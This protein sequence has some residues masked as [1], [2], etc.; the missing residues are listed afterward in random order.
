M[1]QNRAIHT[2]Y[3]LFLIL[4]AL[5]LLASCSKGNTGIVDALN[6]KAYLF[7]YRNL[8]STRIYAQRAI[9]Y[10]SGYNDGYA[11]AL[12][13]LAFVNIAKMKYQ[14]AYELLTSVSKK[15]DNLLEQLVSDIQLM[16]ICQRQS[17]N[18]K[19]YHHLQHADYCIKRI[20][21]EA[22]LLSSRQRM[23]FGY[24]KTEYAIVLSTYLYYVG[25]YAKSA[26]ALQAIDG[27][28]E[29]VK[30]TAQLL[31]YYYNIG[32]GGILSANTKQKLQQVEF[33]YLMRC[34]LLSRQ[35]HFPYWEA[36][37]LQALSEHLQ[38]PQACRRLTASNIQEIYFLNIDEMPD[39]LLAGNLAQRA[40]HIFEDYGD[41]YQVAGA[42]RTLS[43]AYRILGDNESAYVCLNNALNKDT[44]INAAPDLIASI[45]EQ[46]SIV[47]AAMGNKQQSDYNRNIYLDL[48]ERTRQDRQL[49]ARVDSLNV[50]LRQLDIMIIGVLLMIFLIGCLLVYSGYLRGH[51]KSDVSMEKLLSPFYKWKS[52]NDR[53]AAEREK[54]LE[55]LDEDI[56][57][58]KAKME[59]I[60]EKNICQR[61]KVS[62]ASSVVPLINRLVRE[63]DVLHERECK[64][65]ASNGIEYMEEILHLIEL[66]NG[67]LTKWIRLRQ[68]DFKLNIKSFPINSILTSIAGSS[69]DFSNK[70]ITLKVRH[71]DATVKADYTLTLFML[72]T[73]VENARRY[74]PSGGHIMVKADEEDQYVEIS[75]C[76]NGKGMTRQK[77]ETLFT[78][79]IINDD[80]NSSKCGGHGF[81]LVNCKGII[82]KYRKL[83]SVF[84]VCTISAESELGKG[85]R[86]FFRL[87][88]GMAYAMLAFATYMFPMHIANATNAQNVVDWASMARCYADSAYYSNINGNF[89]RTVNFADS[90]LHC[91]NMWHTENYGKGTKLILGGDY[92]EM[93]ADL[94]WF[95]D[96]VK[97]N[98]GILLDIRNET[99]IAALAL[100]R[101]ELYNYNN[102]VYTQL[103]REC[104]ADNTISGYVRTMQEAET[105]RSIAMVLLVILFFCMFPIYYMFYYRY[106]MYSKLCVGKMMQVAKVFEDDSRTSVDKIDEI[107]QIWNVAHITDG[108][109]GKTS[110]SIL[111]NGIYSEMNNMVALMENVLEHDVA[112]STDKAK[113]KEIKQDDLRRLKMRHDKYYVSNNVL[114][115][116]LSALK[117]ETMY[118]PS[119][120]IG[121]LS[122]GG[123]LTEKLPMLKEIANYYQMLYTSLIIYAA[124]AQKGM[125]SSENIV[126]MVSYLFSI[127]RAKNKGKKP[128]LNI[129]ELDENYLLIDASLTLSGEDINCAFLFTPQTQDFDYL[130]CSQI[131]RDFGEISGKWGSGI[132]AERN[133]NDILVIHIKMP[134]VI[135]ERYASHPTHMPNTASLGT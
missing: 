106:R 112:L 38:Q 61:A 50:S 7:H 92:P 133:A 90:C 83:S 18:R 26:N 81:G 25:Q 2:P 110:M 135:W 68:G 103:F 94:S 80:N 11:E 41:V 74:T 72:N 102:Y 115:N 28:G 69:A 56:D 55:N 128:D 36:N 78:H 60:V 31:A 52:D 123:T 121:L 118:Y 127:L 12:N 16:R 17:E 66:Y 75:V 73:L 99:A 124:D 44:L 15:T 39:S 91:M 34:Y 4:S 119:R 111:D 53:S 93:A 3:I 134:R 62:M 9:S 14:K 30:D 29:I 33:D 122:G 32:A 59:R 5:L 27:S 23:R 132:S 125:E 79:G 37:S 47:C 109:S 97:V 95:K 1:K 89:N 22:G 21:E 130:I 116:S 71:S 64:D 51:N 107:K 46:L 57:V 42:W 82:D 40:L 24:A 104:S 20:D 43:E 54:Q 87:P 100:N 98:Y 131:M 77:L 76:D 35:Y 117:H 108:H 86:F 114:E 19:F 67:Q 96:S 45:R 49:E 8:D 126:C 120:L 58:E 129:V 105:N 6:D 63:I 13:N 65:D 101:W 85:S 10:A 84:D 70:G 48:Q 113:E 88:K